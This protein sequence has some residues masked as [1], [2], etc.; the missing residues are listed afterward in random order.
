[1]TVADI[2]KG[3]TLTLNSLANKNVNGRLFYGPLF[4]QAV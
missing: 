3:G 4:F 1:M 2:Q